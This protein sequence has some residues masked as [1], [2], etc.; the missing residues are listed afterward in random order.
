VVGRLIC[1]LVGHDRMTT[2]SAHR[3][4][5]RCGLRES[6]RNYGHVRGWE[7]VATKAGREPSA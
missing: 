7:V 3:T 1:W 6:L 2:A 4:C 5:L